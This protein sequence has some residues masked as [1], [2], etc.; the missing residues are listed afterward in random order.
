MALSMQGFCDIIVLLISNVVELRA[1]AGSGVLPKVNT[2]ARQNL[3][4]RL[5]ILSSIHV[6]LLFFLIN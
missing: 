3:P 5:S 1:L 6:T 4:A 2:S